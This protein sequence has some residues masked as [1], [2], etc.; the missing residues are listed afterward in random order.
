MVSEIFRSKFAVVTFD[1]Q[2]KL[3]SSVYLAETNVMSNSEWEHLM[4]KLVLLTKQY[5]P[6]F[7]I[8]DNRERHFAYSPDFQEWMLNLFVDCWNEIGL[9]KY[10][11][12]LPK[13]IIGKISADQIE[14]LANTKF[15]LQF[16]IRFVLNDES[17][18]EWVNE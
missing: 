13:D 5:K 15:S 17:A 12:I 8:D 4:R 18:L 16:E 6:R 14:E 1:T 3:Y 2:K 11:Q 9:E 7:I 10:V